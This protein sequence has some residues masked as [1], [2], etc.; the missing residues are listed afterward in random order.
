MH[1]RDNKSIEMDIS[2][3]SRDSTN[4]DINYSS[5]TSAKGTTF[6]AVFN[7]LSSM[8][9]GGSLSLPLAF[10][11]SGNSFMSP[12]ML[13]FFGITTDFS[14]M[15]LIDCSRLHFGIGP[16]AR[17]KSSYEAVAQAAFGN[18]MKIFT[19]FLVV[20]ICFFVAVGYCVLLRDLLDPLAHYLVPPKSDNSDLQIED[21]NSDS[22]R[23]PSSIENTTMWIVVLLIT[24][25]C[26]LETLTSL[27]NVGAASMLSVAV[28]G[29]CI[30]YRSFQCNFSDSDYHIRRGV[31]TSFLQ[32]TPSNM[33]AFLTSLPL[34]V[35]CYICHFNVISI[36]NEFRTPTPKKI[37]RTVH[38]TILSSTLFYLWIGW[39]GSMYANCA[40]SGKILG[41]ILLDFPEGDVLLL[42][43]RIC[44]SCTIAF[45]FPMQVIPAR[46][47]FLR[48]CQDYFV[49]SVHCEDMENG[50]LKEQVDK[51]EDEFLT[52]GLIS[53]GD[54]GVLELQTKPSGNTESITPMEMDNNFFDPLLENDT[55]VAPVLTNSF[56]DIL[57]DDT[58]SKHSVEEMR[59]QHQEQDGNIVDNSYMAKYKLRS[60]FGVLFFWLAATLASFVRSVDTVWGL[61]GSTISILIGFLIPFASFV[62]LSRRY[63]KLSYGEGY[64]SDFGSGKKRATAA[65]VL[66]VVYFVIMLLCSY[67]SFVTIL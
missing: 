17:K 24:P 18:Q 38:S 58:Q 62:K 47:T 65:K 60:C 5:P 14:I 57:N 66:F 53:L 2:S 32:L 6:S 67:H 23:G 35:S 51:E 37:R 3:V 28:L 20:L 48:L 64:K 39:T 13:I 8:V 49:N 15:C 1:Q 19:M 63:G 54:V 44:L 41:N 42:I 21:E 29:I 50:I 59:Q 36:H 22:L 34:F 25:L 9:G 45:A 26:T 30:A 11:M 7:L 40:S 16:S 27:K 4:N 56:E 43:A 61:L 33:N 52:N 55:L 10:A 46:D 12:M 31:W